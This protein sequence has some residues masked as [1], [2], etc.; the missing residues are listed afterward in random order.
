[1]A[2]R[3]NPALRLAAAILAILVLCGLG[4][5]Y[6]WREEILRTR[7]DP[8]QPFQTYRP[9]PAPNYADPRDWALSPNRP[10]GPGD[11]PAD[12]FFVHP[13]TY[14]GG[15]DWNGPIGQARADRFLFR[16]VLPNDAGPFQR[17]GRVFAPRYRQASLYAFLTLRDDARDARMFA[18]ADVRAAFLAFLGRETAGRPLILAGVGQGGELLARLVQEVVAH[19]P[20]LLKRL[21]AVY[22]IDTVTPAASFPRG[23]PL[24]ACATRNQARCV[25]AWAPVWAGA[26][27]PLDDEARRVTDRA[28]VW[29]PAGRLVNLGTQAAPCVNPM[30]GGQGENLAPAKLNL[31]AA[32]ASG[33]EWGVRPALMAH[34]VSAQCQ[35]GL[36]RVSRPKSPSLQLTGSW[37]DRRKAAPY[38]LFYADIEA[39]AEAR[40]EALLRRRVYGAAAPPIQTYVV[41]GAPPVRRI[42]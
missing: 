2:R 20:T 1:M 25:A 27:T 13:T 16:V 23:S 4:A 12:V 30:T 18:Y 9:P 22:L 40:V 7:L 8:K 6:I 3:K 10:A 24:P 36:L 17:V 42:D 34:Q 33:L 29:S 14:D 37:A 39:D 5:G 11:P 38:N 32:S 41:V 21:A 19:D 28:L 35:G 31:G 26:S 15:D